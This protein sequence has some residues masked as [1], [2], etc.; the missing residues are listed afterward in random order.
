MSQ[1]NKNNL[2]NS[3]RLKFICPICRSEKVLKISKSII[4]EAKT[5]TTISIQRNEICE[6]HFQAF[7]D[8]N[9]NVRGYQKVDFEIASAKTF[10]KG[11]YFLK[12][13]VIGD[14]QVGKTAI[15]NQFID[16]NF[17]DY[18]IP[19][20][21]L[22]ISKKNLNLGEAHVTLGI[23]DI[24]GQVTHMSPYRSSFYEGANSGIIVVD[25]TRPQTLKDVEM[26]YKDS[27]K[28]LPKKVPFILVGNKTDLEDEIVLFEKDL[29]NEAKKLGL[30]Y[31]I[32]SAKTGCN[33][34]E[35]FTNLTHMYFES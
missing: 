35:L 5:L 25:R 28:S 18:Y 30:D 23:W 19:T 13:I 7:V 11:E 21:Q 14:S 6:H 15:I 24:G 10:P 27:I 2:E 22:R 29:K 9:F 12:V 16:N 26:W 1:D 17:D 4:N 3:I 20:I 34:N 33:I 32:T 8:K 31:C